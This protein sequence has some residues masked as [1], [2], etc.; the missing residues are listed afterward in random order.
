MFMGTNFKSLTQTITPKTLC[1]VTRIYFT[2]K[3]Q[4]RSDYIFL[5]KILIMTSLK[6][7]VSFAMISSQDLLSSCLTIPDYNL[8]AKVLSPD[9]LWFT[10]SDAALVFAVETY[11]KN[12][13]SAHPQKTVV[14]ISTFIFSRFNSALGL[15]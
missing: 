8:L 7:S 4:L 12:L 14:L 1:L 9:F 2:N 3:S 5:I 10:S 15:L 11:L 13:I 6:K